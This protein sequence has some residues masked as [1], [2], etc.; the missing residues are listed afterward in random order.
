MAAFAGK[1][2][3]MSHF[4]FVGE[5]KIVDD[6][7]CYQFFLQVKRFFTQI[8]QWWC[9]CFLQTFLTMQTP[10]FWMTTK[11][12]SVQRKLES[13]TDTSSHDN[14]ISWLTLVT[15]FSHNSWQTFTLPCII[16]VYRSRALWITV[17]ER[18]TAP[19]CCWFSIV[20]WST[21]V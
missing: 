18:T 10:S 1:V 15:F 8:L 16:T 12:S 7:N 4:T 5:T 17:T 9:V 6:L 20:T 3:A 13:L 11:V 19:W 21:A 2:T 14:S